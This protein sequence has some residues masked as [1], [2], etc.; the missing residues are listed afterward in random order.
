MAANHVGNIP[1]PVPGVSGSGRGWAPP[2]VLPPTGRAGAGVAAAVS[3]QHQPE[4]SGRESTTQASQDAG[5]SSEAT[6]DD[7]QTVNPLQDS[8]PDMVRTLELSKRDTSL[9]MK[10][11]VEFDND[12]RRAIEES[13]RSH[14]SAADQESNVGVIEL[15]SSD[16]DED[17]P[18]KPGKKPI[19]GKNYYWTASATKPEAKTDVPVKKKRRRSFELSETCSGNDECGR[20]RED[21]A[22]M[23]ATKRAPHRNFGAD[24]KEAI[25]LS[26]QSD[27]EPM[28]KYRVL[29]REE[30]EKGVNAVVDM[31]GGLERIERSSLIQQG[32]SNDMSKEFLPPEGGKN[33]T[34]AQ[35][36]RVSIGCMYR[37]VDILEGRVSTEQDDFP[38]APIKAFL[39]IG[40]G[41]GIQVLQM[42]WSHGVLSRGCEI[43]K[44][45][46]TLA[47]H[48]MRDGLLDW[49]RGDPCDI[50][51]VD[52]RWLDFSS[53]FN[54]D[55]E[56]GLV[57]I[58]TREFLLFQDQ[59]DE[60]QKGLVVFVNN[61]E[62][63]F[64]PR[65]NQG[66][67]VTSLDCH[68]AELFANLQV[69]GRIVTLT[70][71]SQYL[72]LKPEVGKWYTKHVF[73][74]GHSAVSW[75]NQNKRRKDSVEDIDVV[76]PIDGKITEPRCACCG[77][78][79][80][81]LLRDRRRVKAY[82][83]SVDHF[84]SSRQ[85]LRKTVKKDDKIAQLVS[86]ADPGS[87][88]QWRIAKEFVDP[89]DG[90]LVFFGTV[91]EFDDSESPTRWRIWYDDE[92]NE[93]V[94]EEARSSKKESVKAV[95]EGI[96]RNTWLISFSQS[97]EITEGED[98]LKKCDS[99]EGV[100][101]WQ[102]A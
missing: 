26:L 5:E 19:P 1:L 68:L 24:L 47:K 76:D 38:T 54:A 32:N 50:N 94:D 71:V 39:D 66:S 12:L 51:N 35:Y 9:V 96:A 22:K 83:N 99:A 79:P 87:F 85:Q 92:P 29:T 57:D 84:F 59:Q 62:D 65:S 23:P 53:A 73:E 45:R 7:N 37:I 13:R 78:L 90:M 67:D 33:Q 25:R 60:V 27:V 36:G 91:T 48:I 31:N 77:A 10:S 101:A 80:G 56:T 52:L 44:G 69:G 43:M 16:D 6:G 40:H 86:D 81:R 49:T 102:E 20:V 11:E 28:I 58:D 89:K 21:D 100:A 42:G 61:A 97:R 82:D 64:G 93:S 30:F 41:L 95:Q 2:P 15:L 46:N 75:G 14:L 98:A 4:A 88:I 34:G 74:S 55:N 3:A 72:E 8:V 70:D 18:S 63:V 17:A